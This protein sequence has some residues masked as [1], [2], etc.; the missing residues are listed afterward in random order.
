M[1]I[2]RSNLYI[3]YVL[4]VLNVGILSGGGQS[5]LE[6]EE[7]E[8]KSQWMPN[9]CLRLPNFEIVL[10]DLNLDRFVSQSSPQ[11]GW[12]NLFL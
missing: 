4:N 8:F 6:S 7:S 11:A 5:D 1:V 12:L 3:A 9:F 2:F 10:N